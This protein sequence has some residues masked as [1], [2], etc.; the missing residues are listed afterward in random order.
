MKE[1]LELVAESKALTSVLSAV[2]GEGSVENA[3]ELV[4]DY[5]TRYNQPQSPIGDATDVAL[6]LILRGDVFSK[7][8]PK[9]Y[10]G[11][12]AL[13]CHSWIQWASREEIPRFE[14]L[15]LDKTIDSMV[16]SHWTAALKHLFADQRDEAAKAYL[17]A[18]TLGSQH[19]T[20]TSPV[21]QW[22]FAASFFPH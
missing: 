20:E 15:N 6:Q 14:G 3:R 2:R 1:I 9:N 16:L 11:V 13:H 21:I 7:P 5:R 8:S 19:G 22:T 18:I 17:R 10:E 4:G 12:V